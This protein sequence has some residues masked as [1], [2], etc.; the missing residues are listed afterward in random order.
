[1]YLLCSIQWLHH[2]LWKLS[3]DVPWWSIAS[4]YVGIELPLA[5]YFSH[6]S[7]SHFCSGLPN[8]LQKKYRARSLKA[9][10]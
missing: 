4:Y 6:G 5:V 7:R 2:V 8:N 3:L 9:T 10:L 1:M